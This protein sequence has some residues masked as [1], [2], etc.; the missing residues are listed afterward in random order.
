MV[1]WLIDNGADPNAECYIDYTPLSVA[2]S[3]SN[4]PMVSL[5]LACG[6]NAKKGQ[7]MHRAACLPAVDASLLDMLFEA[8]APLDEIE[9][10]HHLSSLRWTSL[11]ERGTPLHEA[12]K[13]DNKEAVRWLVDRGAD[14]WRR[15]TRGYTP[16]V[17]AREQAIKDR[18]TAAQV[19]R[20][21]E[22]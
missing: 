5:L 7:L 3:E 14:P 2:V 6:G 20:L 11:F 16:D 13:H 18:V 9:Y 15:N 1:E 17:V 21:H 19:M 8:G 4:I 12:C 10:E 22:W